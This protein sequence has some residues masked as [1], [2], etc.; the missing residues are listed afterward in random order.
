MESTFDVFDRKL[1]VAL[2]QDARLS[3]R[4]LA[5]AVGLSTP[6]A[7]ER[8]R[9]LERAGVIRGYAARLD[10]A[11]LGGRVT[12]FL[13][14][15]VPGDRMRAA[16]A[17]AE[18]APEILECHRIAGAGSLLLKAA[19]ADLQALDALAA[20][21]RLIGSVRVTVALAPVFEREARP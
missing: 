17:A 6:A 21:F 14:I 13:E 16:L 10:R 9:R 20:R 15:D 3:F 4:A 18:G 2:Q 7:A 12:A 1:L 11:A 8:V 5:K 19:T